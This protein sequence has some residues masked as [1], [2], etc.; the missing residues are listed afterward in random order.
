MVLSTHQMENFLEFFEMMNEAINDA[1]GTRIKVSELK[2][3]TL[4]DLIYR[5]APNGLRIVKLKKT[6]N[7]PDN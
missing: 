7:A 5:L 3:I 1:G 6:S 2:R 4:L